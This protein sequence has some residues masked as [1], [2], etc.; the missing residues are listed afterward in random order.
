MINHSGVAHD[1][2][3]IDSMSQSKL[4]TRRNDRRYTGVSLEPEIMNYLDDLSR[5]M[6]VDRSWVLN[7]IVYEYAKMIE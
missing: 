6:G 5:R 1:A 4:S 3:T 7:T 2:R